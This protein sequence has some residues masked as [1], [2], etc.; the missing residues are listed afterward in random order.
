MG[1]L[2]VLL[3]EF[4][5]KW[6]EATRHVFLRQCKDGTLPHSVFVAWLVQARTIP[7]S[8]LPRRSLA[9]PRRSPT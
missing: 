2:D 5:V 8:F 3:R 7:I 1:F 6:S 4:E 9:P